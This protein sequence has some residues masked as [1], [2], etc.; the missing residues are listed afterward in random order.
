M[1]KDVFYRLYQPT[2]RQLSEDRRDSA[3]GWC[4]HVLDNPSPETAAACRSLIN[5]LDQG[6]HNLW[7]SVF[8][9]YFL[10]Q[11]EVSFKFNHCSSLDVSCLCLSGKSFYRRS[12]VLSQSGNIPVIPVSSFSD[13]TVESPTFNDSECAGRN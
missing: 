9:F 2:K 6:K 13:Q 11:C 8:I 3:L 10:T 5:R 7:K 4:R 1:S 12:A